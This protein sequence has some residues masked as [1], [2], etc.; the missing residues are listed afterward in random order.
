M[1]PPK[2]TGAKW[3]RLGTFCVDVEHFDPTASSIYEPT[4]G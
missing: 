2:L 3:P 4:L 1:P